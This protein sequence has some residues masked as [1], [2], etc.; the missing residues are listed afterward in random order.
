MK[1]FN[2][3]SI[4]LFTVFVAAAI[5][6]ADGITIT[7]GSNKAA[8][9]LNTTHRTSNGSDHSYIDQDITSGSSPTL[10]GANI[11][12]LTA[13]GAIGGGTAAAGAF[14]TISASGLI[15]ATGGQ[16]AFPATAVPSAVANTLD[17][18]EEGYHTP[19]VIVGGDS[20]SYTLDADHDTL[21]YTK[22]GRKYTLQGRVSIASTSSPVGG[23][24]IVLPVAPAAGSEYSSYI[25]G[26]AALADAGS[27]MP[28][29]IRATPGSIYA[30]LFNAGTFAGITQADVD[31]A[32]DIYINITYFTE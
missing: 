7:P 5:S 9:D 4:I 15:T 32:F 2:T 10:D 16:I 3:V 29:V 12:G 28:I 24:T 26:T 13:P 1:K 8:V 21:Q 30:G 23:I 19:V 17:D 18:Y 27:T 25:L 14:T 11:T 22:I 6:W 31:T 20:G